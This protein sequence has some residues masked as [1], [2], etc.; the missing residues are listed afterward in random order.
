M[1]STLSFV[2]SGTFLAGG[3]RSRPAEDRW[4]RVSVERWDQQ[5]GFRSATREE[6]E[7]V[8]FVS[9]LL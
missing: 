8:Q 5:A 2:L 6:E 3:Q 9:C 1:S 4:L 7:R